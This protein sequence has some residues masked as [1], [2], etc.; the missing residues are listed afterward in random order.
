[1]E[2]KTNWSDFL[3]LDPVNLSSYQENSSNWPHW[4]KLKYFWNEGMTKSQTEIIV[5]IVDW[6]NNRQTGWIILV[7]NVNLAAFPSLFFKFSLCSPQY[8]VDFAV[9]SYYSSLFQIME[10]AGGLPDIFFSKVHLSRMNL[11]YD[12]NLRLPLAPRRVFEVIDNDYAFSL[13]DSL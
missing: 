3:Y 9:Y 8:A 4:L 5:I 2:I 7:S 13:L 6:I 12:S 11:R 10:Q 1:M